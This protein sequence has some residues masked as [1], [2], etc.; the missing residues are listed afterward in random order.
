MTTTVPCARPPARRDQL[1]KMQRGSLRG[2]VAFGEACPVCLLI[3][4][5]CLVCLSMRA[6]DHPFKVALLVFACHISL[7]KAVRSHRPAQ[8]AVRVVVS[9]M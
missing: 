6:K 9:R 5:A 1:R 3:D 4:K 2:T 7:Y 8:G